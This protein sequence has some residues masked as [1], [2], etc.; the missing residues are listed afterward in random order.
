M[1]TRAFTIAIGV[2][3]L[4]ASWLTTALPAEAA[5]LQTFGGGTAFARAN[6]VIGVSMRPQGDGYWI[7]TNDGG[8]FSFGAAP[9]RGSLGN[10]R[11]NNPIVGTTATRTGNGY[12]MASTD[13]GIFSF[14][15]AGFY[16]SLGNIRLN[17]PIVGMVTTRSGKGYWMASTDGGIFSFGDAKFYGSLGLI[18]LNN[19]IVGMAATPSGRGYWMVST[20]GGIF[21]F[22]DAGFYG[23]LGNIRLNNPIT[24]MQRTPSGKGYWMVSSDGGVF[25]FGDAKFY[26]GTGGAC[27]GA[28]V[29]GMSA[30]DRATGYLLV[31]ANGRTSAFA[32]GAPAF[33]PGRCTPPPDQYRRIAFDF[34]VRLNDERSARGL[35]RLGWDDQLADSARNWSVTMAGSGFRHSN[36][37]PLLDR[38]YAA[39]EN[40]AWGGDGATSGQ[41]HYAWM[42]SDGHRAN[43]LAPNLDVVGIGVYCTPDGQL[44]ATQ[45]FGRLPNSPNPPGFG[46]TPPVEPIAR[47]TTDG[48]SCR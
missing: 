4:V 18:R 19:P 32:P 9:F 42:R 31:G 23:S 7:V 22:G 46:S 24:G 6:N 13:G 36:L 48:L 12:W 21:T 25:S 45:Q 15:D 17:N 30:S 3:S 33:V 26:G 44:W 5:T 8:V 29:V 11:L 1:R 40:I 35:P 39:A 43:L 10:I 27:F 34:Y 37:G 2:I 20:D 16:G 41:I 47:P 28:T 38:F 14:G